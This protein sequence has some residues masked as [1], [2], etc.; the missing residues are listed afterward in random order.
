MKTNMKFRPKKWSKLHI[1]MNTELRS[2]AE[3][4]FQENIFESMINNYFGNYVEGVR[5]KREQ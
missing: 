5:K 4:K 3:Y 2:K 1:D